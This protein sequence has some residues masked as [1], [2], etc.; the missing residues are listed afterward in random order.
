MARP[1]VADALGL[2]RDSEGELRDI[3]GVEME[4]AGRERDAER[5]EDGGDGA[6]SSKEG[7]STDGESNSAQLNT[8][9]KF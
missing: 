7:S 9:S 8:S 5:E 3:E 1:N 4:D 6:I 2:G